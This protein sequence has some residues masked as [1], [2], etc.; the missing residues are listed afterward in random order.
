MS[1]Y[2]KKIFP[3]ANYTTIATVLQQHSPGDIVEIKGW[4]KSM[5]KMKD[6][7]FF[8]VNDGSCAR[9]LQVALPQMKKKDNL[10][11]GSSIVAT[12]KLNISPLGQIEVQ[13]ERIEILGICSINEGYPFAPRKTYPPEYIRQYLHLRS[14]TSKFASMLR[15]RNTITFEIHNY[16]HLK[17]FINIHTPILTSNDCEGAGEVFV[18][19]ADNKSLLKNMVKSNV[20]FDQAYFGAKTYLSVS[21]QLHLEAAVHGLSKVYTFGPTFRAENSRS[22]HHLSEFYMLEV[23]IA[24]LDT[25]EELSLFIEDLVKTVSS[26]VLDKCIEDI[27]NFHTVPGNNIAMYTNKK[28]QILSYDEAVGILQNNSDKF[29]TGCCSKDGLSKEHEMFLVKHCGGPV[30]ILNWPKEMKP[31]YMKECSSNNSKVAALDLLGPDVGEIVGGSLREDNYN[32]LKSRIPEGNTNLDWYLDLRRFG[33][34]PTG[35]FGLGLERFIQSLLSINNIRDTLPFPR[36]AHN[37]SM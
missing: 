11:T 22:R 37:C 12:G 32:K 25:I 2:R 20:P 5:R 7:I 15:I 36:W 4:V 6:T 26:Q 23:E 16:L 29:K 21:G 34:V 9:R 14:R 10:T 8:D 24:F 17:G 19:T 30:F 35:G 27:T 33:N 3:V 28:Y 1:K 31:F 18:V 13:A